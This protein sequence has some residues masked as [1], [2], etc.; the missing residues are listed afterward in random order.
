MGVLPIDG[1]DPDGVHV[2]ILWDDMQVGD[3]VFIPCIN[4]S[5]ALSQIRKI[6]ARRKW[7]F[8]DAIGQ[9]KH[10]WGVRIW[11]TS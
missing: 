7:T 10:I 8:R 11:R 6:F 3:S 9:E 1:M 5:R 4:T 2:V